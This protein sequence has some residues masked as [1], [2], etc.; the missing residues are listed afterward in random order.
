MPMEQIS[1]NHSLLNACN[2]DINE[3]L[4]E[5]KALLIDKKIDFRE[6]MNYL[7]GLMKDVS[8]ET[9][10]EVMKFAK[11]YCRQ[12]KDKKITGTW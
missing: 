1:T 6:V 12:V 9:V 4:D 5:L 10:Q 11:Q 8:E 7:D 2:N 3:E